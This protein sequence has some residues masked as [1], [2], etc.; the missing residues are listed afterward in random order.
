MLSANAEVHPRNLTWNPKMKVLE[1]D[2]SLFKWIIFRF[3]MLVFRKKYSQGDFLRKHFSGKIPLDKL[4]DDWLPATRSWRL[5]S[6][7]K[8]RFWIAVSWQ[9]LSCDCF[10]RNPD[11]S[12]K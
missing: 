4:D 5:D 3:K 12:L 1:D 7:D 11:T 10:P 6:M 9:L 8:T 2:F